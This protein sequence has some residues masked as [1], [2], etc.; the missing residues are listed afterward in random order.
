MWMTPLEHSMSVV[1]TLAPSTMTPSLPTLMVIS[2]PLTVG[3]LAP[4]MV[5]TVLAI[6]LP[7]TTWY[8][9][10]SVSFALFSGL[11]SSSTVPAGSLA[12]AASVGAKTVN[13]PALFMVSTRPAAPSAAARVLKA[14]ALTAVSTM[15][16]FFVAGLTVPDVS[17]SPRSYQEV[18]GFEGGF[19]PAGG[20]HCSRGGVLGHGPRIG[21]HAPLPPIAMSQ[22]PAAGAPMASG[23]EAAPSAAP[24]D[25]RPSPPADA[26]ATAPETPPAS[27][28]S[29][30]SVPTVT[31]PEPT[32]A[33]PRPNAPIPWPARQVV[34]FAVSLALGSD[35]SISLTLDPVEL[36]RVEVAITRGAEAHVSLRAERPETL[37]LLQRDR[38][39]LE[40]AL[41]GTGLGSESR[42][43]NLSFG[44]GF[45]GGGEDRR[46]R[47]PVAR[48]GQAVRPAMPT[49]APLAHQA[50]PTARGLIDLAF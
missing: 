30:A 6:T 2:A 21:C 50:A 43:P 18:T 41:A 5:T 45:G 34:P 39:E 10:M 12:K 9:R 24:P 19:Q 29:G 8:V 35:E 11:M 32:A 26:K 28:P 33:P 44:L 17:R 25:P 13:G 49:P 37:A 22:E 15:S 38:A 4:S 42:S 1:V 3:T 14:P 31:T 40:R 46:D 27:A 23:M 36:G 47:R 16:G 48:D 20:V 7:D